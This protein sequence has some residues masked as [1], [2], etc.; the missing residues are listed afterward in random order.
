M[1]RNCIVGAV[2]V[3]YVRKGSVQQPWCPLPVCS[4]HCCYTEEKALVLVDSGARYLRSYA[5]SGPIQCCDHTAVVSTEL[6]GNVPVECNK[7]WYASVQD[8]HS[9]SPGAGG[10]IGAS[11]Y[12]TSDVQDSDWILHSCDPLTVCWTLEWPPWQEAA[13]IVANIWYVLSVLDKL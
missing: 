6:P 12:C 2:T 13:Y 5:R 10:G 4:V 11:C 9:R 1:S 8:R 3:Q 7:L